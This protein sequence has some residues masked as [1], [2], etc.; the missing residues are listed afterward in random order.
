M[1]F[2]LTNVKFVSSSLFQCVKFL[3]VFL[4]VSVIYIIC[5]ILMLCQTI[6]LFFHLY[7]TNVLFNLAHTLPFVMVFS[8]FFYFTLYTG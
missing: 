1:L 4:N 3:F 5:N 6:L 8:L 7:L 2:S